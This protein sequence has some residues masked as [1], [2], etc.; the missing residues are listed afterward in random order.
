[1]GTGITGLSRTIVQLDDA[2]AYF[3][4]VDNKHCRQFFEV[5]MAL[6]MKRNSKEKVEVVCCYFFMSR[7][8]DL[9]SVCICALA[10]MLENQTK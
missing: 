4:N 9:V 6:L 5:I 2:I 7:N 1:M 8:S 10:Q 3:R